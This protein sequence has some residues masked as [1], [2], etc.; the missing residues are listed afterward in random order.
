VHHRALADQPGL[1]ARG[2]EREPE[3]KYLIAV[4]MFEQPTL[5]GAQRLEPCTAAAVEPRQRPRTRLTQ[6]AV[7]ATVD[8]L[9]AGQPAHRVAA[10][11]PAFGALPGQFGLIALVEGDL[12]S[13][14]FVVDDVRGV[15]GVSEA[16]ATRSEH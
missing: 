12:Q 11:P 4:E 9:Q 16:A 6:R 10:R 3:R 2:I 15:E 14:P 8:L 13:A 1:L 7:A 5:T